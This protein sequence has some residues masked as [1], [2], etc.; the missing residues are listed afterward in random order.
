[1]AGTVSVLLGN[2]DGSFQPAFSI[3]FVG[4][5]RTVVIV[6]IV[7]GV[8]GL[9]AV[10]VLLGNGDGS[11]ETPLYFA[12]GP[13]VFTMAVAD[14]N[15]DMLPDVVTGHLG[16]GPR[17][18][19]VTVLLNQSDP[20]AFEIGI[21]IKP[22]NDLNKINPMSRGVIPVAILGTENFD[23]RDVDVETLAFGPNGSASTQGRGGQRRD[24]N[25]DGI[26]DLVTMFR[27]E[28][29]GI[30][31]GDAE[32]C[33]TGETLDG[34]RFEGCDRIETVPVCGS[35]FELVFCCPR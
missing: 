10:G 32:A 27:T 5:P 28:E 13:S 18:P 1:M 2:G 7:V 34:R 29:T 9:A 30:A 17:T 19:S 24:V 33:V 16:S 35:G 12:G 20:P 11:F 8:F 4:R 26:S 25:D 22:G 21:D 3:E 31:F 15:G 6:D 14:L 23:I